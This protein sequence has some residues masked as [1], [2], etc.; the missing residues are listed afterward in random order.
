MIVITGAAS[1][2]GP[3][4]DHSLTSLCDPVRTCP[5]TLDRKREQP[6][7]IPEPPLD[8]LPLGKRL[9]DFG[10][11]RRKGPD[12]HCHGLSE[13]GL[14]HDLDRLGLHQI[15]Q[16]PVVD[17]LLAGIAVNGCAENVVKVRLGLLL[18]A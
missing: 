3:H 1:S 16:D 10:N 15:N 18:L 5:G 17:G 7:D 12:G 2:P 6:Q 11:R 4:S 8:V 9:V 13:P 14:A